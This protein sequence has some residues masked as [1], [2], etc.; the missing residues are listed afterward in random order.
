MIR[1]KYVVFSF[2]CQF[3]YIRHQVIL[4]ICEARKFSC[5]ADSFDI[6]GI[7]LVLSVAV[8]GIL[9]GRDSHRLGKSL[10]EIAVI[11]EPAA[12]ADFTHTY[13]FR[14]KRLGN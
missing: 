13:A 6:G 4:A 2:F 10:K 3:D 8:L 11:R 5:M 7:A 1:N 12:V 14:K 9:L